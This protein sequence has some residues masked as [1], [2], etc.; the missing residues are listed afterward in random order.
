VF[1]SALATSSA[2]GRFSLPPVVSLVVTIVLD[3]LLIPGLGALG[4]AIAASAAY[5]A[6]GV[7]ALLLHRA[8]NPFAASEL[9]PRPSEVAVIVPRAVAAIGRFRAMR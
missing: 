1:S 6:G 4:A 2:P 3:L 8:R 7:T 5:I 9:L